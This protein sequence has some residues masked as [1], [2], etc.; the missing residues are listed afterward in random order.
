MAPSFNE[1]YL[2]YDGNHDYNEEQYN[3]LAVHLLLGEAVLP[4]D[5]FILATFILRRLKPEF[6]NDWRPCPCCGGRI[7]ELVVIA[8]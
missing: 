4:A 7:K 8:S 1:Q 3:V 2:A 5:T 6:Y